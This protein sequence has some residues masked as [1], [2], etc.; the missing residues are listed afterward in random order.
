MTLPPLGLPPPTGRWS[1][2]DL[3]ATREALLLS[4]LDASSLVDPRVWAT[5]G[6]SMERGRWLQIEKLWWLCALVRRWAVFAFDEV[7]PFMVSSHV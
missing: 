4:W 2:I 7:L 1:D 6:N 5:A 3:L